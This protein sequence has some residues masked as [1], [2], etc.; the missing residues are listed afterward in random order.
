M[1]FRKRSNEDLSVVAEP[2]LVL[3]SPEGYLRQEQEEES[4]GKE[5]E[6]RE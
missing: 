1:A 5:V 2:E 4:C 6:E 3:A